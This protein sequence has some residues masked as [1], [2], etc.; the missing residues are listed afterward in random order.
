MTTLASLE[1]PCLIL[2]RVR[3]DRNAARMTDR[4][5]GSGI[6]LRPH[7]KTAK[8]IDVARMAL[9]GNFG[10]I[11]VSTLKEAE[12]FADHGIDD[13]TYA[14]SVVPE[15]MP[16]IAALIRR[17]VRLGTITDQIGMARAVSDRA[18]AER[19]RRRCDDRTGFRRTPRR[20]DCR[21]RCGGGAGAGGA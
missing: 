4:Y 10:G 21:H 11:T 5:R 9:A 3:L 7:M 18:V 12:Y 1:T 6:N 14:V 16:R 2:D 19:C 15:K 17:G 20:S 8:S 13:I